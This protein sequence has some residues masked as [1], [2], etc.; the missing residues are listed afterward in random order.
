[1]LNDPNTENNWDDVIMLLPFNKDFID[2]KNG[3][4]PSLISGNPRIVPSGLT[5]V[6]GSGAIGVNGASD[7]LQYK[8]DADVKI[9]YNDFTIEMWVHATQFT[10]VVGAYQ[11][12]RGIFTTSTQYTNTG[13]N[14]NIALY[15]TH[16]NSLYLD[17]IGNELSEPYIFPPNEWIHIA[18]VRDQDSL[19]FFV[20]G[21]LFYT[22]SNAGL[23]NIVGVDFILGAINFTQAN[24]LGYLGGMIDSFRYT[25]GV[26]RYNEHFTPPDKQYDIGNSVR[27]PLNYFPQIKLDGSKG[28]DDSSISPE[29]LNILYKPP[30]VDLRMPFLDGLPSI[31]FQNSVISNFAGSKY[32]IGS[33]DFTLE[34]W[35]RIP[36]GNDERAIFSSYGYPVINRFWFGTKGNALVVYSGEVQGHQYTR[37][38]RKELTIITPQTKRIKFN[39]WTH[40][41]W[42]RRGWVNRLFIDGEISSTFSNRRY[43][44]SP[45][46]NIGAASRLQQN[47]HRHI[48]GY[49]WSERKF[50][51]GDYFR[52][53]MNHVMFTNMVCKYTTNFDPHDRFTR[54]PT[55]TSLFDDSVV[56]PTSIDDKLY[57]KFQSDHATNNNIFWATD[58]S[59]V[60]LQKPSSAGQNGIRIGNID[61]DNSGT[62]SVSLTSGQNISLGKTFIEP[63]IDMVSTGS[64]VLSN[65]T[66]GE[67]EFIPLTASGDSVI[68]EGND[69]LR[70]STTL[71]YTLGMS[72]QRSVTICNIV[73]P[74]TNLS[75]LTSIFND[76]NQW[77]DF[78][79][80]AVSNNTLQATLSNNSLLLSAGTYYITGASSYMGGT[81]SSISRVYN[82]TTDETLLM[83]NRV[84][85]VN[86]SVC[87]RIGG[88]FTLNQPSIIK[89]QGMADSSSGNLNGQLVI[90]SD[91]GLTT[92][93]NYT[94]YKV[95]S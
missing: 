71:S 57:Y 6:L 68:V 44:S 51:E 10:S 3:Y 20:D 21:D 93:N 35:I 91:Q 70:L 9:G 26:A 83:G 92:T 87:P 95:K 62:L 79:F 16:D 15:Y 37:F 48:S 32:R 7:A 1:M 52:G 66:N 46:T 42:S 28:I 14:T 41:S 78:S 67:M 59:G 4:G 36:P 2:A 53:H 82:L 85:Y 63:S 81:N 19:Y 29:P 75:S 74:N 31:Q 47:W 86:S 40:V 77:Y 64:G 58:D 11:E 43:W 76:R 49:L 12:K 69:E 23:Y 65:V 80:N 60:I 18:I 13:Y 27:N 34:A 84:R 5:R 17:I 89:I 73:G 61:I 55:Y 94:I 22:F 45:V 39:T 30:S 72:T 54:R 33:N 38:D 25:L 88:Y 56:P 24:N 50:F 90:N 8:I